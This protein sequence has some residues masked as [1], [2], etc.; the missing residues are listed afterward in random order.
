MPGELEEAEVQ[1]DEEHQAEVAAFEQGFI[2][3]DD[4][5]TILPDEQNALPTSDDG[6]GDDKK[7]DD[8][9]TPQPSIETP[10][11][12]SQDD[13]FDARLKDGLKAMGEAVEQRLS[14]VFGKMGGLERSIN[15]MKSAVPPVQKLSGKWEVSDFKELAKEFPDMTEWIVNGFNAGIG[16]FSPEDAPQKVQDL[17]GFMTSGQVQELNDKHAQTIR[18]QVGRE[19]A[20]MMLSVI[21][22]DWQ[23]IV[24]NDGDKNDYRAWLVKQPDAYQQNMAGSWD[25]SV[26]H[27][28]IQKFQQDT[29][30]KKKKTA[31]DKD[32][33]QRERFA[34]AVP[35][36]A[37]GRTHTIRTVS[38]EEAF[39]AGFT[40][41][42]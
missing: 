8:T 4:P 20:S 29:L 18:Q 12:K 17:S 37:S 3:D 42:E 39:M 28:S 30:V 14:T 34:N 33:S 25:P 23:K 13:V 24:G 22:P 5:L 2:G 35:V 21:S 32:A 6:A 27:G 31:K 36:K 1:Q 15:E 16:R 19:A 38:E 41:E 40:G 11:E 10:S 9:E 7:K 26:V